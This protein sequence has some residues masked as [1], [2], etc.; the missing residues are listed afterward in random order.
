MFKTRIKTR[1]FFFILLQ[2][3]FFASTLTS[4]ES[5]QT[6]PVK[7]NVLKEY[8]NTPLDKAKGVKSRVESKQ[9]DVRRQL[10]DE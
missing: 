5:V 9:E 4:C 2:S 10:L 7:N 8:I 3:L 1:F 6:K